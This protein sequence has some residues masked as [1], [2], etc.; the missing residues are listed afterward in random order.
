MNKALKDWEQSWRKH[1]N[2][3]NHELP[4]STHDREFLTTVRTRLKPS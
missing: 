2:S 3:V 4:P 1:W